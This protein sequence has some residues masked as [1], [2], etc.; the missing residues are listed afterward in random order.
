MKMKHVGTRIISI[1]LSICI[2]LTAIPMSAYAEEPNAKGETQKVEI[3]RS[4]IINSKKLQDRL[5]RR[6]ISGVN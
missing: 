4:G 6:R 3:V 2:G 5:H 1:I